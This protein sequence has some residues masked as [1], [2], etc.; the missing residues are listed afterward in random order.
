[1]LNRLRKDGYSVVFDSYSGEV[2]AC[3]PKFF[4]HYVRFENV[5][6]L[7]KKVYDGEHSKTSDV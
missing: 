1:M 2:M 5:T 3:G 7:Y 4:F 6:K